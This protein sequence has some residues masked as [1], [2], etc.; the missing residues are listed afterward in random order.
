MEKVQ[1]LRETE[2]GT[3]KYGPTIFADLTEDEFKAHRLGL[4]VPT[5]L[6]SNG[7]LSSA[8]PMIKVPEVTL[9]KEFDWRHY[10]AVTEV[11]NQGKKS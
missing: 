5:E 1:F 8:L 11:K 4:K 3:G 6:Q 10:N 2:R 7:K 9:P